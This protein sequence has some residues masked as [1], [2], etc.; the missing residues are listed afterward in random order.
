MVKIYLLTKM[1][2][3]TLANDVVNLGIKIQL[4]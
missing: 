4:Y 2:L 1:K 3:K